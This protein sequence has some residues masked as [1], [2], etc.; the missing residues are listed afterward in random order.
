MALPKVLQKLI[1]NVGYGQTLT[2]NDNDIVHKTGN[3]TISGL[4]VVQSNKSPIL[5]IR[6]KSIPSGRGFPTDS[7]SYPRIEFYGNGDVQSTDRIGGLQ[8]SQNSNE[9]DAH[10]SIFCLKPK[11]SIE[12]ESLYNILTAGYR[13]INDEY[14]PYVRLGKETVGDPTTPI[15]LQDGIPTALTRNY[16]FSSLIPSLSKGTNPSEMTWTHSWIRFD[17]NGTNKSNRL[18]EQRSYVD[19]EGTTGFEILAYDYHDGSGDFA[20]LGIYNKLGEKFAVCPTPASFSDDSER[21]ATT[22][23][24]VN[25]NCVVHRTGK[26]SIAGDKTFLNNIF[27]NGAVHGQKND[28]TKGTNPANSKYWSHYFF[29]AV[30]GGVDTHLMGVLE[31]CLRNDGTMLTYLKS[32]KNVADSSAHVGVFL[33]YP[34]SGD[35]SFVPTPSNSVLCGTSNNKWKEIW[36][37]Q[38]SINSS[39]D[40]RIK[41]EINAIPDDILDAWDNVNWIQ[42]KYNDALQE[43]GDNARLHN[44]LI[45]QEVDRAFKSKNLDVSKYGLFLY[46]EWEA[47]PEQRDENGNIKEEARPAGDSYGLRYTEALCMEAAYNRRRVSRLEE[48]V[49]L[50]EQKLNL[51]S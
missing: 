39:S 27:V 25:A 38:S 23:W 26:E 49:R 15:Y 47:T 50:L 4:K 33:Q 40:E 21:I 44:G 9:L 41:S 2:G 10:I 34:L 3:E 16:S 17:K 46:D 20:S 5:R 43:K 28:V 12:D 36:C 37:T 7:I 13:K 30:G 14:Q 24:V 31:G 1:N 35:P 42:F 18:S 22:H 32:Y 48:K 19:T 8:I 29:D 11:T 51:A 45:A 6:D